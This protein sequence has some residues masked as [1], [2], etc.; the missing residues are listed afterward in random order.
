MTTFHGV[1]ANRKERGA[2]IV[3]MGL[4]LVFIVLPLMFGIMD[5]SRALY[6]YHFVSHTAREATRW[7]SVRGSQC[8]TPMTQCNAQA[9]DVQ[10][11]VEGGGDGLGG[12]IPAGIYWVAGPA[13][14]QGCTRHAAI[15]CL[16]V[17]AVWNGVSPANNGTA[18]CTAGGSL[19]ANSP[20]CIVQ[21]TV[22]YR[23]GF[24]FPMLGSETNNG[25]IMSSV[26]KMTIS[27]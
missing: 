9:S 7:A 24:I 15:G 14:T 19:P 16:S 11:Y 17:A 5:F 1:R 4:A 26:S 3:E 22:T 25:I 18:D 21:V 27:Q 13:S 6:A 10:Y 8:L 20:G 23:F 2:S 12:I